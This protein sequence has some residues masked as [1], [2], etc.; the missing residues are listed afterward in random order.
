MTD[1]TA[2][3]RYM[4]VAETLIREIAAGRL[5]DGTRLPAERAMAADLCISMGTLR[6]A[7]ARLESA[8]LLERVQGSG[9]YVRHLPQQL[10]VY[11]F[12]RL[13]LVSGGGLPT[14]ELLSVERRPK[15]AGMP[16]FGPSP[17]GHR[18]RRL[19]R[20]GD[21]PA[22]LE[23]IWLDGDAINDIDRGTLSES[24]YLYYR[25]VLGIVITRAEDRIGTGEVP[26]WVPDAC[27]LASG[28]TAGFIERVSRSADAA[29]VE[30]SR[31]W[32]D[33]RHVRYVSRL[34]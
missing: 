21:V 3:P 25:E 6:R 5:Q 19:R 16:E 2:L 27:T 12:F 30:F 18:I 8:G 24:L 28:Q 1:G 9:N 15:E 34:Q 11:A 32:F 26:D 10:G 17:E 7:L 23:E 14:A 29:R 20:I 22:V 33:D 13:E 31:T 4:Q